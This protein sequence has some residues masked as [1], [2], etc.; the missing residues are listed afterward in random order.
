M[1]MATKSREAEEVKLDE[2]PKRLALSNGIDKFWME[3]ILDEGGDKVEDIE[4]QYGVRFDPTS[5]AIIS[6]RNAPEA[7]GKAIETRG[8]S[9]RT[10]LIP[11]V[12]TY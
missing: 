4:E 7:K 2:T 6:V 12:T 3:G 11:G 1:K 8:E 10:I 9:W 5:G